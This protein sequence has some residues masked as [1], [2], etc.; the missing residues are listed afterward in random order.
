MDVVTAQREAV[1]LTGPCTRI[2]VERAAVV[3]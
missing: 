2:P 3:R 1:A